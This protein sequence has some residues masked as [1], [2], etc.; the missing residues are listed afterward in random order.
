MPPNVSTWRS[1]QTLLQGRNIKWSE[2]PLF[3][4]LSKLPEPALFPN[5]ERSGRELQLWRPQATPP[6]KKQSRFFPPKSPPKPNVKL[7]PISCKLHAYDKG[8]EEATLSKPKTLTE[9]LEQVVQAAATARKLACNDEP[10]K[11]A[12]NLWKILKSTERPIRYDDND[13]YP[14]NVSYQPIDHLHVAPY[15]IYDHHL[16]RVGMPVELDNTEIPYVHANCLTGHANERGSEPYPT[17][18]EDV[19]IFEAAAYPHQIEDYLGGLNELVM[20]PYTDE[21]YTDA[22]LAILDL[23]PLPASPDLEHSAPIVTDPHA[24]DQVNKGVRTELESSDAHFKSEQALFHPQPLA[25]RAP[26]DDL[27]DVA[28]FLKMGHGTNCWCNDCGEPPASLSGDT[29]VEDDGWMVYSS[30]DDYDWPAWSAPATPNDVQTWQ[31]WSLPTTPNEEPSLPSLSHPTP[32][33]DQAVSSAW[34]WEWG[35]VVHDVEQN[36]ER[37]SSPYQPT[38]D[39]VFTCKPSSVAHRAW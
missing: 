23:P 8:V 32:P 9:S 17:P 19:T 20:D 7:T 39:E 16:E 6:P 27:I 36:V 21:G 25:P 30:T 18:E 29:F 14:S 5:H 38:W 22:L 11:N 33:D 3:F 31:S 37:T 24:V 10:D 12:A 1:D 34:E 35:T 4:D 2:Y 15:G 28:T 26:D 13:L